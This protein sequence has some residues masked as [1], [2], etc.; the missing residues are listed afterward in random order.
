VSIPY[1]DHLPAGQL[2]MLDALP[3]DEGAIGTAQVYDEGLIASSFDTGVV[4]GDGGVLQ[5]DIV[6]TGVN[7][8]VV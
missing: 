7:G 1:Q 3:V 6:V 5:D 8:L 4:P 2:G